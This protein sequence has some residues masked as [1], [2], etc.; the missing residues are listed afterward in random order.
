MLGL[1][2]RLHA[3][4]YSMPVSCP[5]EDTCV[6]SNPQVVSEDGRRMEIM[7]WSSRYLPNFNTD[8]FRLAFQQA[9]LTGVELL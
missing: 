5:S 1:T 4:R 3:E 6:T 8:I 9:C 7:D 2:C